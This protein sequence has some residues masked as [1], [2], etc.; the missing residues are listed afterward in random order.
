MLEEVPYA[1]KEHT[2]KVMFVSQKLFTTVRVNL[3]TGSPFSGKVHHMEK[4][5]PKGKRAMWAKVGCKN[6]GQYP[7]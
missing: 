1:L 5:I 7:K 4:Q 6:Q 2:Y 3:L